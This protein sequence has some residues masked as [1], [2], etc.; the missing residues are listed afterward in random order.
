MIY[1]HLQTGTLLRLM[2]GEKLPDAL[3]EFAR[4]ENWTSGWLSGIGG[5]DEVVLA[6]FDRASREYKQRRFDGVYELLSCVGNLSMADGGPLWHLH[7]LIG[8]AN[9]QVA[10]GHLVGLRIAVTGEF[11][12]IQGKGRVDRV[13]DDQTG[14]RLLDLNPPSTE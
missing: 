6:Y 3:V 2:A 11:W 14:L 13:P 5:V 1:R 12:L 10:G 7:A 8:D 9:Y 4:K